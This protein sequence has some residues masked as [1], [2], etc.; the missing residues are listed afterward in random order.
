MPRQRARSY[1]PHVRA[2]E[3]TG[4]EAVGVRG[5]QKWQDQM[6]QIKKTR[7]AKKAVGPIKRPRA[8][9]AS[10]SPTV[11][12]KAK[13]VELSSVETPPKQVT[14]PL[15]FWPALSFAMM[16]MWLGWRRDSGANTLLREAVLRYPRPIDLIVIRSHLL[17]R[18]RWARG[19]I[20]PFHF[21]RRPV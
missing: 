2:A 8:D 7:P 9:K 6:R 15:V 20:P 21:D 14:S 13:Q 3:P 4:S 19:A 10:A 1:R 17:K 5:I 11:A 16:R 18:C 12:A